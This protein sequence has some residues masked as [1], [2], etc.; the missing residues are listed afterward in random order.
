MQPVSPAAC[1]WGSTAFV[2][3]YVGLSGVVVWLNVPRLGPQ[4][5]GWPVTWSL[6]AEL[7]ALPVIAA[8]VGVSLARP[9]PRNM[10]L[11]YGVALSVVLGA[12]QAALLLRDVLLAL[13]GAVVIAGLLY[14]YIRGLAK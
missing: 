11:S 8:I 4:E 7:F 14:V 5:Y 10:W 12:V 1:L 3:T 13:A 6:V 9:R 2:A